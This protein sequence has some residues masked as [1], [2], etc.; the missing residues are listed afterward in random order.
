MRQRL[1]SLGLLILF[2]LFHQAYGQTWSGILDPSRAV[3]WSGVGFSIPSYSTACA[4]Q[5]SLTAGS[6]NATANATSIANSVAS[7]DATHNVVNI[8]AGTYYVKGMGGI[9]KS[10]VVLRGAG[11]NSTYLYMTGPKSGCKL[12]YGGADICFDSSNSESNESSDVLPGGSNQCAWT[13]GL[14]RGSTTITLTSCGS[15]HPTTGM[16]LMLDQ[17][18]DTA[19]TGGVYICDGTT[20][21]CELYGAGNANGRLGGGIT[22]THSEQEAT[23][24]TSISGSGSGP[25]TVTISPG[26]Y[27]NNIRSGQSPGAWY[28]PYITLD[29][30][31][32]MTVDYTHDT[33]TLTGLAFNACY[34]CWARN[35][36]SINAKYEHIQY[37]SNVGTVI[38]DSY[39]YQSQAHESESYT[40]LPNESSADLIENNIFQQVNNPIIYSQGSG[41][42]VGYN[43]STGSLGD[44]YM[45]GPYAVHNAG[46]AFVLWEGNS[47]NT[48]IAD[49]G[50]GSGSTMTEF[51]NNL[52]GWQR[53]Y[54]HQTIPVIINSWERGWNFIGNVLGEPGF[55]NQY[56]T[57]ATSTSAGFGAANCF[58]SIYDFGWSESG[59]NCQS[60]GVNNDVLVK[61][62]ALRWG[63]WDVATA[64]T[65]WCGNSSDTGWS[66][67]CGS[68]SEIPTTGVS[69]INGNPV[70]SEGDIGAGQGALPNSLY[71]PA[72]PSWWGSMPFPPIGPDVSS[73]NAGICT[74]GTYSGYQ[75]TTSSQCAGGSYTASSWAGHVNV[76]PAEN[77]YLSVMGGLP[78]GTGSVLGFD[79]NTCYGSQQGVA[80]A[81]PTGLTAVVD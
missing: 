6:G 51:R 18:N 37:V 49:I 31:E 27:F 68:A 53:N 40:V 47:F 12:T 32:N 20:T 52:I 55:H 75:A 46:T 39:F 26:V 7:C 71:L 69:Y 5:P 67:T 4:T 24:I 57:Y 81:A 38:R 9:D 79:A 74:S 44:N 70:P 10:N 62:T 63:N 72:K 65:H 59:D 45:Q 35:I 78:D 73:G 22:V 80:P 61:S 34:H 48:I 42:V 2:T 41:S 30:V 29:G 25:Y 17:Q 15:T 56:Q 33:S 66:T 19:D 60:G 1:S 50:W 21:G 16:I 23:I 13:G 43:F 77:C 58:T 3:D 64:A 8:P 36:R 54:G 28:M 14:S 11:P 76:N